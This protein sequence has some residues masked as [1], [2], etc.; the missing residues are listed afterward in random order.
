MVQSVLLDV[1]SEPEILVLD[2]SEHQFLAL[3]C[4]VF[5][6][7]VTILTLVVL[8]FTVVVVVQEHLYVFLQDVKAETDNKAIPATISTLFIIQCLL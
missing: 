6:S 4:V 3:V 7:S 5:L 1:V 8:P 2:Q